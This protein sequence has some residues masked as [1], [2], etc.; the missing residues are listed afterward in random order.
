LTA[1]LFAASPALAST[2][3]FLSP[4]ELMAEAESVVEG[5]IVEAHSYWN[6][7]RTA[8]LTDA[9]LVVHDNVVGVAEQL[10]DLRTFGGR[11]GDYKIVAHGFPT[12]EI[13]DRLLLFLR[14]GQDGVHAVAGYLQGQLRVRPG[15]GGEP[16]AEP[17]LDAGA[18]YVTKDGRTAP[19][20]RARPLAE[21]KEQ[22]RTLAA[23][24]GRPVVR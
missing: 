3:L 22:L 14:P 15:P 18:R 12:F 6:P 20:P 16:V 1:A 13:G 8:I 24:E 19:A 23:R 5:E 9:V 17:M 7:E 21:V 4:E 2:F 10:V 11:V